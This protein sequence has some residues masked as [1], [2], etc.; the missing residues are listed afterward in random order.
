MP[1]ALAGLIAPLAVTTAVPQPG[2]FALGTALQA[3]LAHMTF[4][5]VAG[6]LNKAAEASALSKLVTTSTGNRATRLALGAVHVLVR[7]HRAAAAP[8]PP[9]H[10]HTHTTGATAWRATAAA[11]ARWAHA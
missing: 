5:E 11:V 10:T 7:P 6:P 9:R 2:L 4:T 3:L 8:P 1:L